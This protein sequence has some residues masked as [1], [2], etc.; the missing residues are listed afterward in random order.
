MDGPFFWSFA[1]WAFALVL[2]IHVFIA[3]AVRRLLFRCAPESRTIHPNLVW[4]LLLAL[5][6]IHQ[7]PET[8]AIH[9]YQTWLNLV[10]PLYELGFG[11][12]L[13]LCIESTL[14]NE[15]RRRQATP[16]PT[17]RKVVGII[18][19]ISA[20]G[21]WPPLLGLLPLLGAVLA[22]IHFVSWVR[23]W[24]YIVETSRVLS[25]TA[26]AAPPPPSTPLASG[27]PAR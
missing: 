3:L 2:A 12:F 9:A 16:P 13:V 4:L 1:F 21:G 27:P 8:R 26:P 19:C 5:P 17:K 10:A 24:V 7:V 23:Y 22:F 6:N 20:L 14:E 15:F 11:L 25:G 18:M